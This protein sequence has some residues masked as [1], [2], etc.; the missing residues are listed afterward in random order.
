MAAL[1]TRTIGVVDEDY[2]YGSWLADALEHVPAMQYPLCLREFALMAKDPTLSA[3]IS[4]YTLQILRASWGVDGTGCRPEIV[5]Q[6]ADDLGLPIIGADKPGA[7]RV[8][9]VSWPEHLRAALLSLTYGHYGFEL[10]AELVDGQARLIGLWD[11]APWTVN[12]IHVDT[13]TGAFKGITQDGVGIGSRDVPQIKADRMVWYTHDR[14]G[15]DHTGNSLLRPGYGTHLIKREILRHTATAHRR[16]SMGVPT[17]EWA[18]GSN[19]TQAQVTA[20]QQ[21]ASAAR[22]GETGGA[23]LPPG[24]TLKLVGLS[25]AVPDNMALLRWLDSQLSRFALMPHIE[26]G[27]NSAGGSRALGDSFIDSWTLS[28]AAIGSALADQ[29]TR[30]IAAKIVEWNHGLDE[31]VPSIRVN[32]IGEQREVTAESLQLLLS[33]GALAADPGLEAWV[34]REYR[35]PER[36][37]AATPVVA[38]GAD[39]DKQGQPT[40]SDDAEP[41]NVESVE[42]ELDDLPPEVAA[43]QADLDWGLFGG[44]KT[45]KVEQPTLFDDAAQ[46]D[47]KAFTPA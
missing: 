11:R 16:F 18:P 2:G 22:V 15:A 1:P 13:K 10:Q 19:P 12:E 41:D 47:L 26:L 32:G 34:R 5:R 42:V 24:A 36:E 23:S 39:L 45:D 3:I 40:K 4:S 46:I 25:G 21:V 28:L 43:R 37:E 29:A 27:Q 44:P 9:G 14:I 8:R 38:P 35:L 6:V 20:A 7:A 31:P 17:V 30:Q 33:S